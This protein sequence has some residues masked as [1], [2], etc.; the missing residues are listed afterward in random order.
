MNV[1]VRPSFCMIL[2]H[3]QGSRIGTQLRHDVIRGDVVGL[4]NH[5]AGSCD[6]HHP[7]TGSVPCWMKYDTR[8]GILIV[9]E[10]VNATSGSDA[11]LLTAV[12]R[13]VDFL[14]RLKIQHVDADGA[15]EA[16]IG[17]PAVSSGSPDCPRRPSHA[18]C[19]RWK[20]VSRNERPVNEVRPRSAGP[21]LRHPEPVPAF[22]P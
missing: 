2:G 1:F 16:W 12:H 11:D 4:V 19:S 13:E 6:W 8:I 18:R 10:A 3:D 20:E 5:V 17:S 15:V 14:S 7:G 22:P 9:L 21:P